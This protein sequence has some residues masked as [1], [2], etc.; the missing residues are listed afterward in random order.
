MNAVRFKSAVD[1]A[2]RSDLQQAAQGYLSDQADH[3][4]ANVWSLLKI[5]ALSAASVYCYVVALH[6]TTA[7]QFMAF[8]LVAVVLAM[9]LAMNSLHDVAHGSI[10]RKTWQNKWLTRIVSLPMGIDADIWTRRHVHLHHTY[11][12]MEGYDLDIEPNP[13]LR[14]TPFQEW[15][16][17]FRYQ[18]RYWPLIAALSLTYLCWWGDW[19]DLLGISKLKLRN[20]QP[21]HKGQFL[22]SKVAHVTLMLG[23]PLGLVPNDVIGGGTLVLCYLLALMTASCFLVAMILGPHWADVNFFQPQDNK[24]L[25]HTWH[26]HQFF[27]C[28]DWELRLPAFGYWLGGLDL[29]LTH[30]LLPTYSHRHYRAMSRIIE[31]LAHQHKLP[32]RRLSYSQLWQAQQRFLRKM[33]EL[34]KT[35]C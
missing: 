22:L 25:P 15:A 13:F 18:H 35:Y 28:C 29:H 17:Q 20:R 4:F 30:H 6:A 10:F 19:L 32:Y 2:F 27:T 5:V 31:K 7:S 11:P 3:R 34:P 23:L 8:Y 21:I 16:P 24:T 26:E 1:L 33:G 12:N 9:F 14:Q